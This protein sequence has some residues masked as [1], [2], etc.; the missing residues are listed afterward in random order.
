[1]KKT[2][3]MAGAL[4]SALVLSGCG[5]T[6]QERTLTGAAVGGA[7]GAIIGGAATGRAGGAVAGGLIGAA[8]GGLIGANS[9]PARRCVRVRYDYYG[10]PFCTRWV[11]DY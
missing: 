3:L 11:R 4:T 6:R 5:E 7:T 1:M 2:L 8:A 9:G 10:N